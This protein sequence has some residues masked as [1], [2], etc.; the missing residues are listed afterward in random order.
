MDKPK[1]ASFTI[2]AL[3]RPSSPEAEIVNDQNITSVNNPFLQQ[4]L[5]SQFIDIVA[6][7]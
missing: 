3:I 1:S 2:E 5:K 4:A 6:K 7:N